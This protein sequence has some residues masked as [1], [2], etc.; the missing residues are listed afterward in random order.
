MATRT[1]PSGRKAGSV[2]AARRAS[3]EKTIR[4]L[5]DWDLG[6]WRGQGSSAVDSLSWR[7]INYRLSV[8]II[9]RFGLDGEFRIEGVLEMTARGLGDA[10]EVPSTK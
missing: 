7:L 5:F 4:L 9:N 8:G 10:V 3:L 2:D 6:I 1:P